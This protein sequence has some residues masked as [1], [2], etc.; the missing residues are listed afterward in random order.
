MKKILLVSHVVEIVEDD[1]AERSALRDEL[2]RKGFSILEARDGEEGLEI[3][4]REY[5][6]LILLDI[7]MPK[8]NGMAMLH[9]LRQDTWGKK[10]PVIILTNYDTNDEILAGIVADHPSYYLIKA[11][12]PLEKLLEKIEVVLDSGKGKN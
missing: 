4:L 5:P 2:T 9:K 3:A 6:D 11:N 10:T 12:T 8:M 1:A 7:R